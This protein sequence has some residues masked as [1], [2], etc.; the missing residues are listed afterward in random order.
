MKELAV[1]KALGDPIRLKMVKRLASGEPAT[2]GEL[3]QNLGVSRQAARKQL[4]VLVSAE[5]AKLMP[6][7]R[8]TRVVLDFAT[9]KKARDFITQIE[10]QWDQRLGALK[11]FVESEE[12]N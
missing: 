2:I 7:G 6:E 3:S 5:V 1:Y 10:R 11:D 4:E 12:K 9:L 8:Q